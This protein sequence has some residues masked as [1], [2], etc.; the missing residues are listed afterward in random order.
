M[1]KGIFPV[2]VIADS[3]GEHGSALLGSASSASYLPKQQRIR[4]A[5]SRTSVPLSYSDPRSD[6]ILSYDTKGREAALV[7]EIPLF[8]EICLEIAVASSAFG[9]P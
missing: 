5:R 6:M 3:F 4:F 9:H 8:R 2:C 7:N 1:K